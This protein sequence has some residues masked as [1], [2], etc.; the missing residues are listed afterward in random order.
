MRRAG[1]HGHR[2]PRRPRPNPI[3]RVNRQQLL[4]EIPEQDDDGYE[5]EPDEQDE[6]D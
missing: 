3:V 5:D 1:T 4:R 6:E 2:P